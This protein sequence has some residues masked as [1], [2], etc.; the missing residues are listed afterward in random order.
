MYLYLSR[1]DLFLLF[2]EQHTVITTCLVFELVLGIIGDL[3]TTEN[4]DRVCRHEANTCVFYL[5][6]VGNLRF[7]DLGMF[8]SQPPHGYSKATVHISF[9]LPISRNMCD[10]IFRLSLPMMF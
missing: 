9:C 5:R 8:L 6:N 1:V 4:T 10:K 3:E 2:P 7:R